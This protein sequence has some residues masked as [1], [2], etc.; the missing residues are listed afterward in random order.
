[1]LTCEAK[2]GEEEREVAAP[3]R[4][5]RAAEERGRVMHQPLPERYL[6]VGAVGR[7]GR[8]QRRGA[9]G[10]VPIQSSAQ[11]RPDP[12]SPARRATREASPRLLHS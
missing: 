3:A 7:V 11:G 10:W 5:D 4:R 12:L 9:A 1:M 2:F 8:R 6:S